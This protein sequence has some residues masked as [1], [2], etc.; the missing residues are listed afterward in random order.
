A[1]SLKRLGLD[2]VDLYQIHG[3]DAVTPLEETLRALD[4]CVSRGLVN[5]IGCSNWQA[6]RISKALGISERRGFAR[7]ETVQAYYSIAGRDLERDIVPMMNEEKLGLM[8][9]SPLAGGLLSGKYGPGAPGN[10]EGRRASFDFPPVDKDKAWACVAVMREIAEKHGSNVATVALAYVLAKP[11]VT[12]VII[13]AK[14]I[15]QLDQNLAAV[16]LK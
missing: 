6:W 15:E 2:H 8:V 9:W 14:R 11:F 1:A 12:S 13:G 4:D 7:F 10:G 5:T 16:T 3:F